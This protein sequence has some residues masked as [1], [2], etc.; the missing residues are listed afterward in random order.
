MATIKIGDITSFSKAESW[1]YVPDDRQKT[2]EIQGGVAVEDYGHV[3][4][5]DKITFSCNFRRKDFDVLVHY[6]ADRIKVD[7]TDPGGIIWKGCRVK[8][9]G[10]SYV[11]YFET[12][13]VKVEIELWRV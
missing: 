1:K 10:Y 7:F 6:W 11:D 4:A 12:S 13:T 8:I 2:I 3:A 5:G 9:T